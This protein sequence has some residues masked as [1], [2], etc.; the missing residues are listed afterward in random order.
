MRGL[1]ARGVGVEA[2]EHQT[3]EPEARQQAH[4]KAKVPQPDRA[5]GTH[6][7]RLRYIDMDASDCRQDKPCRLRV[8]L[9]R[10]LRG[11]ESDR[12]EIPLNVAGRSK[13][14]TMT[15]VSQPTRFDPGALVVSLDSLRGMR[16]ALAVACCWPPARRRKPRR[17]QRPSRRA[18]KPHRRRSLTPEE[19]AAD[20]FGLWQAGQYGRMYELSQPLHR[21]PLRATCSCAATRI[22]ATA[23]ARRG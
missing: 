17:R 3:H 7:L 12:S 11:A 4:Q 23:S 22:S 18:P 6:G 20:Y 1:G 21:R 10:H 15:Q 9:T 13:R 5:S 8:T 14:H 2:A 16:W 19:V